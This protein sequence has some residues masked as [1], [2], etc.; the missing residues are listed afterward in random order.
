MLLD[1]LQPFF[2][3]HIFPITQ[4]AQWTRKADVHQNVL[5]VDLWL[6]KSSRLSKKGWR[7]C[8]QHVHSHC[9][10]YHGIASEGQWSALCV[11]YSPPPPSPG[12]ASSAETAA[13]P[14]L[15]GTS[16]QQDEDACQD[17]GNIFILSKTA[18]SLISSA[19]CS[20]SKIF[21]H[22]PTW[23][24]QFYIAANKPWL[25]NLIAFST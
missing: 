22:D 14:E 5:S 7:L 3:F 1:P 24:S 4:P 20:R 6:K 8:L 23:W 19:V 21:Y 18:E 15:A 16:A 12:V 2:S 25:L 13:E 10:I 17:A 9:V 11:F